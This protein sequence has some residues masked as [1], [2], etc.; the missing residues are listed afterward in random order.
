M[1]IWAGNNDYLDPLEVEQVSEFESGLYEYV[2]VND[3]GLWDDIEAEKAVTDE[4]EERIRENV[5]AW[6]EQFLA[7]SGADTEAAEAVEAA[8]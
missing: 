5:S 1:I 4:L 8:E 7:Q 2:D 3:P 6:Q